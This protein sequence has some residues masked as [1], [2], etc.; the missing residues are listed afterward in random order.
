M[1]GVNRPLIRPFC[2]FPVGRK[3]KVPYLMREFIA[4]RMKVH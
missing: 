1:I 3:F 2:R 4:F